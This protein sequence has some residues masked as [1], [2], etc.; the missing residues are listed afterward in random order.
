M[1]SFSPKLIVLENDNL[2]MST[3]KELIARRLFQ[4]RNAADRSSL[5]NEEEMTPEKPIDLETSQRGSPNG[6]HNNNAKSSPKKPTVP[7]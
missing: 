3:F 4:T 1:K 5:T 2:P 6:R 7:L